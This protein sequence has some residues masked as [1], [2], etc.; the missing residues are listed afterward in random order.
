MHIPTSFFV[1]INKRMVDMYGG[2]H[3]VRDLGG[4]ESAIFRY[5]N[6]LHYAL[7]P[8]VIAASIAM[9]E[10]IVRNHPFLDGNK[11][12]ALTALHLA[13]DVNGFELSAP[14]MEQ[15]VAM[16]RMASKEM[17]REAFESWVR[18]RTGPRPAYAMLAAR[19]SSPEVENEQTLT[20]PTPRGMM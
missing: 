2:I 16:E 17:S 7:E 10:G 6:M 8:D 12:T 14:D 20:Q 4:L 18:L 15:V 3:G 9:C 19:D 13:L 1:A 5:E 11:R